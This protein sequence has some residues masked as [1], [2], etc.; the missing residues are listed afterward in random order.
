MC[1][2]LLIFLCYDVSHKFK[3]HSGLHSVLHSGRMEGVDKDLTS[4]LTLVSEVLPTSL[5]ELIAILPPFSSPAR[6]WA[7][8]IQLLT[9]TKRSCPQL[10]RVIKFKLPHELFEKFCDKCYDT[11]QDL[12]TDIIQAEAPP[13]HQSV[14][15]FFSPIL[16][17]SQSPSTLF[18][19][20][21]RTAKL[22]F[23]SAD[24]NQLQLLSWEK[25]K[26]SLPSDIQR[27]LL[28]HPQCSPSED[29]LNLADTLASTNQPT[30]HIAAGAMQSTLT[31]PD[32]GVTGNVSVLMQKLE[33]IE[34]TIRSSNS[35]RT[36]YHAR[37]DQ[38]DSICFYHR[39]FGKQA[40]KCQPPC[41]F[42]QRH[43][44]NGQ[45]APTPQ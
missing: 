39:R 17:T 20:T 35:N 9:D 38:D 25:V 32:G 15:A 2:V 34:A 4:A 3:I 18:H 43:H 42:S 7:S 5:K 31:T 41:R 1:Y 14:A 26:R 6:V 45:G 37:H 23:P 16:N 40:R 33:G 30:T 36:Q 12:L 11:P 28:L 10:V 44:L 22:A 27:L 13:L 19:T 24:E 29:V 21:L 8:K